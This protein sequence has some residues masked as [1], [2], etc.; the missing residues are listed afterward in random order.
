MTKTKKRKMSKSTFA[1]II[2]AVVMVAMLAFGGSYAYFT[3][4]ATK[5]SGDITTGY[6]RLTSAATFVQTAT[7]VVPGTS[8]IDGAVTVTPTQDGT[9]AYVAVRFIVEIKKQGEDEFTVATSDNAFNFDEV[10]DDAAWFYDSTNNMYIYGSAA[11]TYTEV[12]SS[13]SNAINFTTGDLVFN[14]NDNWIEGEDQSE[15]NYMKATIRVTIR[16][17]S[18]QSSDG[19]G[20]NIAGTD[21]STQLKAILDNATYPDIIA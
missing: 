9:G 4:T 2:M 17:A 13:S 8:I 11:N 10:L 3:A 19:Q 6:V 15:L 5:S 21:V 7:H 16:A 12:P 1:I 18:I 20:G 14:V